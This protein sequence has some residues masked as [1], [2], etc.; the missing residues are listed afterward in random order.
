MSAEDKAIIK[1]KKARKRT[2]F[3]QK[4]LGNFELIFPSENFT[5]ES[6]Q[7]YLDAALEVYEEFNNGGQ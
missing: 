5:A 6:H 2:L 1:H 3:E 4:N 7:K